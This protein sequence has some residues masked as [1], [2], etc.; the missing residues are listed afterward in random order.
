M[1]EKLFYELVEFRFQLLMKLQE[2][3]SAVTNTSLCSETSVFSALLLP[4]YQKHAGFEI[5]WV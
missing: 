2:K 1:G 3:F 5:G 4:L